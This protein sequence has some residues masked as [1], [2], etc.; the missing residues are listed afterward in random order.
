MSGIPSSFLAGGFVTEINRQALWDNLDAAS[1]ARFSSTDTTSGSTS[2]GGTSSTGTTGGTTATGTTGGFTSLGVSGPGGV[3][4]FTNRTDSRSAPVSAA[5]LTGFRQ[6][7][8]GQDILSAQLS[9]TSD[10]TKSRGG[11]L[12]VQLASGIEG[13]GDR[14]STGPL[15]NLRGRNPFG[16]FELAADGVTQQFV[17][18]RDG[19]EERFSGDEAD[20]A[21]WEQANTKEFNAF[22]N[23]VSSTIAT[24]QGRFGNGV[25]LLGFDVDDNGK[26]DNETELFGFD[27]GLDLNGIGTIRAKNASGTY[28]DTPFTFLQQ[29]ASGR[30]RLRGD[31]LDI[32]STG[33]DRN[34]YRR[35]MVLTSTGASVRLSQDGNGY[36]AATQAYVKTQTRLDLDAAGGA[37]LTV[38]AQEGFTVT[39]S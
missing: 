36:D 10:T 27:S 32:Q 1:K 2:S 13:D 28:V 7:W 11:A 37:R 12:F 35:F 23:L 6:V 16:F 38:V 30:D 9:E 39:R 14:P 19:A 33:E 20:R 15:P 22:Q 17:R 34:L 4:N 5:A 18:V 21:A 25:G 24:T 3:A 29:D 26:I 31:T 8:T